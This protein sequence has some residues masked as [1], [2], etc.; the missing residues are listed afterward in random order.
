[1]GISSVLLDA[2]GSP[3]DYDRRRQLDYTELLTEPTWRTICQGD[4]AM[5]AAGLNVD[6][7][8]R[9]LFEKISGLPA[10]YAPITSDRPAKPAMISNALTHS[11]LTSRTR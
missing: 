9:F 10:E 5:A 1:V 2:A 11:P 4:Q 3:I 6:A 7:A 8:K